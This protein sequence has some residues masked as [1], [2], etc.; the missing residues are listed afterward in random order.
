MK[1][2]K[3]VI[4]AAF[5]ALALSSC[6]KWGL[7]E[8]KYTYQISQETFYNSPQEVDMVVNALIK[9]FRK[10]Y[11]G[12]WFTCAEI[13]AEYGYSKGVYL[14]YNQYN[15]I[16]DAT[17]LSR[18]QNIFHYSYEVINNANQG[19]LGV[20]ASKGLN[21]DQKRAFIAEMRFCRA[22]AYFAIYRRFGSGPL[23]TEDNI[24]EINVP[25]YGIEETLDY[26]ISELEF[27]AANCPVK[28]RKVGTPNANVAKAVLADAYLWKAYEVKNREEDPASWYA[29]AEKIAEEVIESGQYSLVQITTGDDWRNLYGPELSNSVE[30]MFYLKSSRQDGQS[31]NYLQYCTYPNFKTPDDG[32]FMCGEGTTVY[33][34]HYTDT[35]N[36]LIKTWD[37]GDLRKKRNVSTCVFGKDTYGPT[38][39]LFTKFRD[40]VALLGDEA[41]VDVPL[42]RYA[43]VILLYIEAR[44]KRQGAPDAVCMEY[45]NQIRRRGY[46]YDSSTPSTTIDLKLSNYSSY[47]LFLDRLILEET[48]EHMNEAKHWFLLV[49]QGRDVATNYIKTY[50]RIEGHVIKRIRDPRNVRERHWLWPLPENEFNYNK[51]MDKIHDQ[52]PGYITDEEE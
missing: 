23:R 47:Q 37:D 31:W 13:D 8:T 42:V 11:S 19:I 45:L 40:P 18:T 49:R 21:E 25:R 6:E 34:T 32:Q 1:N 38:T 3:Y 5:A 30:E 35:D 28:A 12:H 43:D 10:V 36:E 51:A 46:G 26:I 2:I 48:Y 9:R 14:N 24:K 41:C 4:I 44:L 52:N 17:Q 22:Y 27:A 29:A 33:Y 50:D 39:A 16:L 7:D 15:G 20:R